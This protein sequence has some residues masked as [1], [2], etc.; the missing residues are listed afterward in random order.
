MVKLPVIDLTKEYMKPG[1]DSWKSI[2]NDVRHALEEHGGFTAVYDGASL[3][4]AMF[5]VSKELFDLPRDTKVRITSGKLGYGYQGNF[6]SMP[7]FECL[8]VEDA[9]TLE[10]T[11]SFTRQLWPHGNKNF[12]TENSG[13]VEIG[14]VAQWNFWVLF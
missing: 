6:R 8:G 4:N 2:A 3:H 7:L 12:R 14:N 5:K 13:F 11:Q 9:A 1:T 10:G